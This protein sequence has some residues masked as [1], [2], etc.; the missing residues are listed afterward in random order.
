VLSAGYMP[1]KTIGWG[2]LKP[3]SGSVAP[4]TRVVTV[5]PIETSWIVLMLA[6]M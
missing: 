1:Q 5:S 6:T 4:A 3:G 2:F